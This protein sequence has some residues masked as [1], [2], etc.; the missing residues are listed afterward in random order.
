MLTFFD[1]YRP[2]NLNARSYEE[3][4]ASRA[5][6]FDL[7][8]A[9]YYELYCG[10][11]KRPHRHQSKQRVWA[12]QIRIH[13]VCVYNMRKVHTYMY[14]LQRQNVLRRGITRSFVNMP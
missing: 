13:F 14:G 4:V 2:E 12:M 8:G 5:K 6:I 11:S 1:D 9:A 3:S 10:V 7:C